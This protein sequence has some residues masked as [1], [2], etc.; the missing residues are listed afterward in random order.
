MSRWLRTSSCAGRWKFLENEGGDF[1]FRPKQAREALDEYQSEAQKKAN[2]EVANAKGLIDTARAV[3]GNPSTVVMAAIESVPSIGAGGVVG[4]GVLAA[5]P[6]VGGIVAGAMGEGVVSAGQNAE[7]VRQE[8]PGGLL[9]PEQSGVLAASGALTGAL[10]LVGG[11]AAHAMGI[12]DINTLAAGGAGETAKKGFIKRFLEGAV[13]EGLLEELPQSVQEQV[14]QNYAQGKPLDEGVNQAAVLGLFTGGMIGGSVAGI[15]TMQP[16]QK[17]GPEKALADLDAAQDV[18]AAVA[19]AIDLA[20]SYTHLAG[21]VTDYLTPGAMAAA[22]QL[23]EGRTALTGEAQ[24]Q[25]L[26]A[27]AKALGTAQNAGFEAERNAALEQAG[28]AQELAV[29]TPQQGAAERYA[30]LTP[31]DLKQARN[32]LLVMRDQAEGDPNSLVIVKH[33]SQPGAFAIQELPAPGTGMPAEPAPLAQ[34]PT[35]VQA[36]IEEASLAGKEANR[37]LEDRQRQ[38][39][40]TRTM[41]SISDRGGVAS[42]EEAKILREANLG[43]PYDRID[44]GLSTTEPTLKTDDKLTRATGIQLPGQPRSTT[45]YGSDA[46]TA[47]E[48]AAQRESQATATIAPKQQAEQ[49]ANPP[50]QPPSMLAIADALM[51]AP[52]KRTADQK[53]VINAARQHYTAKEMET[54]QRAADNPASLSAEERIW[55]KGKAQSDQI[56]PGVKRLSMVT[57]RTG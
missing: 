49:Q 5:A 46:Q 35:S 47:A 7:Q 28:V 43:R 39:M 4:R 45:V 53:A 55:I 54:L 30:D 11:K 12:S 20:D 31:M 40:I 34:T 37:Q 29:G 16:T 27:Q 13:S 2:A 44:P 18:D 10:S 1:G 22:A 19:A 52:F 9:T 15:H 21:A 48:M 32:R 56:L 6:K 41:Q 24:R 3:V 33:P 51:R 23:P 38:E 14:A 42:P 26:D 8:T 57:R 36:K 25:A 17:P 50:A